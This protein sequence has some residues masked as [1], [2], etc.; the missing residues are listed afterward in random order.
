MP[1]LLATG[2]SSIFI[3]CQFVN[4][5]ALKHICTAAIFMQIYNFVGYDAYEIQSSSGVRLFLLD[6]VNVC[7][8]M[9]S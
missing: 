9:L 5:K 6:F 4:L 1:T 7:K 3:Y 2:N 8:D